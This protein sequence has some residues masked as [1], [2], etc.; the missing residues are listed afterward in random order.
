[1]Q[2]ERDQK[3][4]RTKRL[5]A[6]PGSADIA[7]PLHVLQS[8]FFPAEVGGA[9]RIKE[10]ANAVSPYGETILPVRLGGANAPKSLEGE[11]VNALALCLYLARPPDNPA[12]RPPAQG[13]FV[14]A[15]EKRG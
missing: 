12:P 10:D 4:P 11:V 3:I 13:R 9:G 5:G 6:R 7:V 8:A 14:I 15:G 2:D 1:L